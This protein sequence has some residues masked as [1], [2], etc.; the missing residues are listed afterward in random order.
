MNYDD[1]KLMSPDYSEEVSE[2]CGA[3]T[4]EETIEEED[5]ILCDSCG[6]E[7]VLI[8]EEEYKHNRWESYQ[9]DLADE[10]RHEER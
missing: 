2:C 5:V 3:E 4:S 6:E 7:C 10:R 1:W 9:E 8:D